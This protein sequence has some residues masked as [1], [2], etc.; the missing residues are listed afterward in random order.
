MFYVL[1]LLWALAV[2][3]Q[4][5]TGDNGRWRCRRD[6]GRRPEERYHGRKA[7]REK[8][9]RELYLSR[10]MKR[11]D[12]KAGIIH[13]SQCISIFSGAC[14]AFGQ[15]EGTGSVLFTI[16][17]LLLLCCTGYGGLQ[18]IRRQEKLV[19]TSFCKVLDNSRKIAKNSPKS[20]IAC[21]WS[22]GVQS[23]CITTPLEEQCRYFHCIEREQL[24]SLH[25]DSSARVSALS[26]SYTALVKIEE[27]NRHHYIKGKWHWCT[28]GYICCEAF[29]RVVLKL[30]R[31]HYFG[32]QA[33]LHSG[34]SFLCASAHQLQ[35]NYKQQLSEQICLQLLVQNAFK[36]HTRR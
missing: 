17:F 7:Y 10:C 29:A 24:K 22:S 32:P 12:R 26:S 4:Q 27:E 13:Q 28:L 2:G 6:K 18:S 15:L 16:W 25:P 36:G 3:K 19:S 33:L 23:S 8:S 21:F 31:S 1:T 35:Y 9:N 5:L 14:T 20:C 11:K 30:S 34:P